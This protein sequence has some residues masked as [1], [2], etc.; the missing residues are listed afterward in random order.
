MSTAQPSGHTR[1]NRTAI[2]RW[3]GTLV[4]LGLFLWLLAGQD[5]S[6][7]VERVQV[8]PLWV[9]PV[10][11]ALYVCGLGCNAWRWHLLLRAQRIPLRWRDTVQM[12]FAGAFA[13]NFLPSTIGGDVV[14]LTGI[15]RF[16]DNLAIGAGSL[17]LDRLLN[18]LTM[19]TLFPFAW[20]VFGSQLP[21]FASS[22]ARW[23][24]TPA[25]GLLGLRQ[26]LPQ[27]WQ[28]VQRALQGWSQQPLI[29][30]AGYGISWLSV[31]VIF[32]GTWLVAWGLGMGV[33]LVEVMAVSAITYVV[34][35]LPIS[36]NGY[37]VRE[38]L[39]TALY[40]HLGAAP[41]QAAALTL[42]TRF[43]MLLETLPGALW[44]PHL[45]HR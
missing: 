19:I 28:Q 6:R 5:W 42:L 15:M 39:F 37:G 31:L 9:L 32:L 4:G 30:L 23:T 35:L 17:V 21:L 36:F 8:M 40:M 12:I 11:L 7:I 25:S 14:R 2:L 3:V 44:L 1:P 13:S 20:L 27:R 22:T 43:L 38:V 33:T 34:T 18:V 24:W 41:E 45:L 16:T 29:L 10:T 26:R